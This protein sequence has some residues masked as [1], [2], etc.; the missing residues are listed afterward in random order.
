MKKPLF[1][2]LVLI[3]ITACDC[4][5]EYQSE[6]NQVN[7]QVIDNIPS[8]VY[9]MASHYAQKYNVPL[10]IF[11]GIAWHERASVYGWHDDYVFGYGAYDNG[12]WPAQYAGWEKQ[13]AFAAPK[14]GRFF[15]RNNPSSE[16]FQA[17]ARDIYKT[18]AWESYRTAYIH[19]QQFYS[20]EQS[21][22]SGNLPG[23]DS[24]VVYSEDDNSCVDC[25][26]KKYKGTQYLCLCINEDHEDKYKATRTSKGTFKDWI[27]LETAK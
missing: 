20:Q 12:N 10:A 6:D 23:G 14:I 15:S 9:V 2:V 25:Q 1:I 21:S 4:D 8:D 24:C 3:T 16:S 22:D 26:C 18:T 11:L 27:F 7:K 19:Y 5:C 17:F 13:W